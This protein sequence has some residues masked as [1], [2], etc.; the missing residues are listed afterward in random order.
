[1]LRI[2]ITQSQAK[3]R[4]EVKF[5]QNIRVIVNTRIIQIFFFTNLN[6]IITGK[7]KI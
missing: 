4:F 5:L 7:T 6:Y 2:K 3:Q 1:M